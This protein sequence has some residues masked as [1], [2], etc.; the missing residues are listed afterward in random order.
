MARPIPDGYHALT[1]SLTVK[2]GPQAIDFYV[3]AFGA[4]E[5][6]RFPGPDG[7]TLMHAEL[8]IG[9][10]IFMLAEEMPGMGCRAPSPTGGPT[11]ALYVYVPDVDAA[12]KRAVDAGAKSLMAVSDMFWGDRMG[13]VEDPAGHRWNLATHTEDVAPEQ[14]KQRAQQFFASMEKAEAAGKK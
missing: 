13:Q 12:F 9:D 8:K 6:M 3:K 5:L 14:L 4:Q 10:S 11:S 1:P 7:K 2:N